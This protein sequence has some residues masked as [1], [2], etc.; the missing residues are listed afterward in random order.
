MISRCYYLCKKISIMFP[1]AAR[2]SNDLLTSQEIK[3]ECLRIAHGITTDASKILS[4][5]KELY[6]FVISNHADSAPP[7]EE[8]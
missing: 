8:T 3:L 5:A 1:S 2:S 6:S 4:L 7:V